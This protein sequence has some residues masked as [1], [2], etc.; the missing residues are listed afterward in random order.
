MPISGLLLTLGGTTAERAETLHAIG[1]NTSFRAGALCEHWL[2]LAAEA[3]DD[4]QCRQQHY[5]LMSLPAVLYVDVV[6]VHFENDELDPGVNPTNP[7][8]D[9]LK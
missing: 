3:R 1:A 2:P 8:A 7:T 6:S 9:F 5:W 4:E